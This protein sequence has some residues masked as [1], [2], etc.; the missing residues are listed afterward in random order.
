MRRSLR[1]ARALVILGALIWG[2]HG[3]CANRQPTHADHVGLGR[4]SASI[5]IAKLNQK[6]YSKIKPQ[7]L[8]EI[9][10]L[11]SRTRYYCS[12]SIFHQ[13][14][15]INRSVWS[16]FGCTITKTMAVLESFISNLDIL[17]SNNSV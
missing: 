17:V 10:L 8:S 9:F 16:I 7:T 6:T 4:F 15:N 12:K 5:G 13:R 3:F 14:G 11:N 1:Q 2:N